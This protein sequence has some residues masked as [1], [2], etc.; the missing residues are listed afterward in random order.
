MPSPPMPPSRKRPATEP[1]L[2]CPFMREPL[3][4]VQ[5]AGGAGWMARG[6][7]Y[8]TSIF[9]DKQELLWWISHRDSVAPTF[10]K[11]L[12]IKVRELEPPGIDPAD[13]DRARYE[14]TDAAIDERLERAADATGG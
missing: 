4:I 8:T 5:V 14:K 1:L 9:L 6:K 12:D 3:E 2:L 11:R 13:V 7:F 10:P